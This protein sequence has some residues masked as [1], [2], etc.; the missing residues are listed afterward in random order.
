MKTRENDR[1]I[2]FII[3]SEDHYYTGR[4]LHYI[5][6]KLVTDSPSIYGSS[7]FQGKIEDEIFGVVTTLHK[8][9]EILEKCYLVYERE[10]KLKRINGE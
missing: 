5:Y 9:Y 7:W 10:K 3:T 2:E 8:D 4:L 6:D 1:Y